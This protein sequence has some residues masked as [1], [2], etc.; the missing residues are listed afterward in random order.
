M[1]TLSTT[2]K[3]QAR[4][5][6]AWIKYCNNN[7][8]TQ[9]V[10]YFLNS[11]SAEYQVFKMLFSYMKSEYNSLLKQAVAVVAE[12]QILQ[13]LLQCHVSLLFPPPA[14]ANKNL[15]KLKFKQYQNC[16]THFVKSCRSIL[17]WEGNASRRRTFPQ[18]NT[19]WRNF[20]INVNHFSYILK[21]QR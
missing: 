2:E 21:M 16:I 7:K 13:N 20:V 15:R 1:F 19:A 3:A 18:I 17:N 12:P 14:K 5:I 9:M 4:H 8:K 10:R 6:R 11:K